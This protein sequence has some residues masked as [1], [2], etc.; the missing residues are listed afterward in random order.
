[1]GPICRL[2]AREESVRE[3][4]PHPRREKGRVEPRQGE[5]L[6]LVG[7]VFYFVSIPPCSS[8]GHIICSKW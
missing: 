6:T 4:G 7:S 1:M 5:V 3:R 2:D 8:Y